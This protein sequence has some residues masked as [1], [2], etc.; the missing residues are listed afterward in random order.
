LFTASGVKPSEGGITQVTFTAS[1]VK[2]TCKEEKRV[3]ERLNAILHQLEETQEREKNL[4]RQLE[5]IQ[6][7]ERNLRMRLAR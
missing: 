2:C 7:R 5:E 6:E 3:N 4:K 1:T